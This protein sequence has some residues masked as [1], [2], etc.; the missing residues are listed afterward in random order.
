[1]GTSQNRC[2]LKENKMHKTFNV[3]MI[4]FMDCNENLYFTRR[5]KIPVADLVGSIYKVLDKIFVA[6]QN[7]FNP[8]ENCCSVSSGDV[9]EYDSRLWLIASFGFTQITEDQFDSL[10]K[11]D[12]LERT[13]L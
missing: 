10:L 11:T 3:R 12:R 6:G 8:V 4:M 1:M 2:L 9:I 7:D 13:M 5:V